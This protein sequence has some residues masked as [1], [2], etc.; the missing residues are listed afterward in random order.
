[1]ILTSKDG[2]KNML[3]VDVW[4]EMRLLDG[5][6]QNMT[7]QHDDEYFTYKEI[8]AKWMTDCFNNDIL[9]LDYIMED[10]SIKY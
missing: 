2:D 6:I 5:Y 1:M 8:C 3:R 7:V 10:V 9:N 4:K